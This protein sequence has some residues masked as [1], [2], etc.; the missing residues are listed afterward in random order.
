MT[1]DYGK[2][3]ERKSSYTPI[4]LGA[5]IALVLFGIVVFLPLAIAGAV[6]IGAA[7]FMLF[8]EGA[9]EKFA[10]FKESLEEKWPLEFLSKEKLGI[11]LFLMSEILIFGS[12]IVAYAYVRLSSSSW[13]VATQTH[14]VILGMSNTIIL[15]TSSLA[16]VYA[17]Y[18]IRAGNI[19]GLRIGLVSAFVLGASFLVIKLGV[20]WPQYYRN[21]FTI[22][23]GLPGST[24]FVLT[25]LHAV[26]VGGGL[27]GVGYL[28]FRSFRGGFTSTKHSAV[29]NIGLYWHFVDIVWMFLFPLFYL[30]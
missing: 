9:N 15:L 7:V 14:D 28:I 13:P 22:S 24:Y 23:S 19:K 18:S 5:G 1:E 10:E 20:E 26:H 30:I 4:I 21:G 27:V 12:L 11:W 2:P 16:I 25:G 3:E 29:E 17:L 6:V 8:K